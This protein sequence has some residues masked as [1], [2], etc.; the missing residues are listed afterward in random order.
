MASTGRHQAGTWILKAG[1]YSLSQSVSQ[2]R[3]DQI[4]QSPGRRPGVHLNRPLAARMP[5]GSQRQP[6][7]GSSLPAPANSTVTYYS[8]A[9]NTLQYSNVAYTSCHQL[10]VG[11]IHTHTHI[12][13]MHAD[14]YGARDTLQLIQHQP[15]CMQQNSTRTQ[16]TYTARAAPV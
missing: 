6:W 13:S 11:K 16:H 4:S 14:C 9:C 8:N 10:H 5:Y 3:S 15:T 12:V 1:C 2:I 7:R